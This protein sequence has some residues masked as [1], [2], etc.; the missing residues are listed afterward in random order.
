MTVPSAEG[1]CI[2]VTRHGQPMSETMC[3]DD[4]MREVL[5]LERE[6]FGGD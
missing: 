3:C 4:M 5:R 6:V 1:I 2:R